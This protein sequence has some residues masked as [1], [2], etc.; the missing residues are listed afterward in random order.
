MRKSGNNRAAPA[1]EP[2]KAIVHETAKYGTC[3]NSIAAIPTV[4]K[5]H[6]KNTITE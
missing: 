1:A 4:N 6:S 2:A 3:R 5:G